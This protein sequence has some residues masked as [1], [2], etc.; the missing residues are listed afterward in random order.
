MA[1]KTFNVDGESY[2][3]YSAHCKRKG[4]S[5]SKQVD[6]FIAG[7]VA[8]L[9]LPSPPDFSEVKKIKQRAPSLDDAR[10]EHPMSRYC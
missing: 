1:L 5:M 8:R 3:R 2:K 7:E 4:I 9:T 10:H 6:A